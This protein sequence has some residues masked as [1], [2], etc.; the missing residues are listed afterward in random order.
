V[1]RI[2]G[3]HT[4]FPETSDP[5]G[6]DETTPTG[7]RFAHW[8][9]RSVDRTYQHANREVLIDGDPLP[10]RLLTSRKPG[11]CRTT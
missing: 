6:A 2:P 8:C 7:N 5:G 1:F 10:V 3:P 9:G 11:N 4:H